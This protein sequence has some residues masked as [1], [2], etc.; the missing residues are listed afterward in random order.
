MYASIRRYTGADPRFWEQIQQQR[1]SLEAAFRQVRGFQ[2]WYLV[3]TGD[4][5]TT[6]TLCDDQ[7]GADESVQVAANWLRDNMPGLLAG[8]PEVSNGEVTLHFSE[9]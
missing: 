9:R 1:S 7:A 4:G 3:R 2:S 6:I 5:L 8:Q